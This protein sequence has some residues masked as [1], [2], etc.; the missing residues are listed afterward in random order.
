MVM[1]PVMPTWRSAK[2]FW[3]AWVHHPRILVPPPRA[4][5]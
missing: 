5:R 1:G 4:L 3:A 2:R